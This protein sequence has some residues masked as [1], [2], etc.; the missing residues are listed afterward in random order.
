MLSAE[1]NVPRRSIMRGPRQA[2]PVHGLPRI[3]LFL[4]R[5]ECGLSGAP[6]LRRVGLCC[7]WSLQGTV[8]CL[9]CNIQGQN[10]LRRENRYREFQGSPLVTSSGLWCV[11]L[12]SIFGS[13]C[14]QE[15]GHVVLT[16]YISFWAN[17]LIT[18]APEPGSL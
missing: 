16:A 9:A 4:C 18:A 12:T 17:P 14:N 3:S 2:K 7:R 15:E 11:T 8:V 5:V 10:A 6:L 1:V 13:H